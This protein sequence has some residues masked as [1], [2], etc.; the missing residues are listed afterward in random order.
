MLVPERIRKCVLFLGVRQEDRFQPRATAFAV[1]I[2]DQ[3]RRWRYL[4]T[5]EHVVG[6][7]LA[8][9]QDLW[10]RVNTVGADPAEIKIDTSSWYFHPNSA[11]IR[12]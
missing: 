7:S 8:L 4:V 3:N 12:N 6:R 11:E 1:E 10:L 5:A 2:D 9:G